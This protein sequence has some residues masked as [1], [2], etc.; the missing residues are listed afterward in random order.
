MHV[1]RVAPP[2]YRPFSLGPL[3]YL[4]TQKNPLLVLFEIRS[5]K[6][7]N[8]FAPSVHTAVDHCW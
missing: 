5:I 1:L 4:D 2:V 7:W 3:V 6:G 8:H